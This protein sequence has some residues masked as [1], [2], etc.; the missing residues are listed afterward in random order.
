MHEG[1]THGL[2]LLQ[3]QQHLRQNPIVIYEFRASLL[4]LYQVVD[5]LS[6]YRSKESSSSFIILHSQRDDDP[7]DYIPTSF[8]V[9]QW[10][11]QIGSEQSSRIDSFARASSVCAP[12]RRSTGVMR[13]RLQ[14]T[15]H[16]KRGS[17]WKAAKGTRMLKFFKPSRFSIG[18]NRAVEQILRWIS[19]TAIQLQHQ[20]SF[21]VCSPTNERESETS[22]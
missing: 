8:N 18:W 11:V 5:F 1:M 12:V 17:T 14:L 21:C 7:S 16:E 3:K 9:W 10:W 20:L 6:I 22:K 2:N 13:H 19:R 4:V 15:T